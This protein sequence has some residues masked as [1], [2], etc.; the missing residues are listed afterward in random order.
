[1]I[2]LQITTSSYSARKLR[3]KAKENDGYAGTFVKC[4]SILDNKIKKSDSDSSDEEADTT[5]RTGFGQNVLTDE[6]L[7][8]A[9][10]GRTAHK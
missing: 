5:S 10:G 1:M 7:L 9:C 8:K 6:E 2:R 3:K 4:Q